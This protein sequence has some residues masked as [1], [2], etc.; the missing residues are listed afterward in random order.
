MNICS[1]CQKEF[2]TINKLNGHMSLHSDKFLY[3]LS[4]YNKLDR[5]L[6]RIE[7]TKNCK[8]CSKEFVVVRTVK[9]DGSQ[10]IPAGEK[11]FCCASCANSRK[12][13]EKMTE[14][15]RNKISASM[16]KVWTKS[17]Y[18]KNQSDKNKFFLSSKRELE[19]VEYFQKM[20]P[21]DEWKTQAPI[22]VENV[23]IMRDLWSDK[24]KICFE[25]D[26]ILHFSDIFGQ[27]N[28]KLKKDSL[29]EKWCSENNYRLVRIDDLSNLDFEQIEKL[30][31]ENRE[32]VLKIG[33]RFSSEIKYDIDLDEKIKFV[34]ERRKQLESVDV[35]KK[36]WAERVSKLWNIDKSAV[37][38]YVKKYFKDLEVYRT[39]QR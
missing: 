19:I 33:P 4:A 17:E 8:K 9:K 18:I 13:R 39:F 12:N 38:Y 21:E 35:T 3:Y 5:T 34:S 30:L 14:E 24:L 29:L 10:H 27:L 16:K 15:V 11:R 22:I 1:I 32:A 26:G 28:S 31:Y 20:F 7:I 36:G 2:D 37:Y 23:T 25:Y 6:E